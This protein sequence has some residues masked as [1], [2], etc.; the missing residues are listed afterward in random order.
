MAFAILRV[1]KLKTFGNIG[2]SLSHNY[3][4]R[5]TL[6]ADIERADLNEHDLKTN[7]QTMSA[8]QN[9]IPEKRRKDAVLCIEHLITASPHW[10]GWGTEKESEFFEKSKKWLEEKYGKDNLISTTIHR[11]ETTPHLVAYVVPLDESTGRLNA[12]K[13]LGGTRHTLT[14]MQTH[15]A[16]HVK[17]VGLE[18]GLQGSKAEH[19]TI[20]SYYAEIQKPVSALKSKILKIEKLGY[21]Q[22]PKYHFLDARVLHGERVMNAVYEN[23]EQQIDAFNND[24]KVSFSEMHLNFE[25][26]L[27][28]EKMRAD[29]FENAHEKAVLETIKL[30]EKYETISEYKRLFPCEFERLEQLLCDDVKNFHKNIEQ[31]KKRKKYQSEMLIKRQHEEAQQRENDFK[32]NISINRQKRLDSQYEHFLEKIARCTSEPEKIA[33]KRIYNERSVVL[34]SDPVNVMNEVL[35]TDKRNYYFGLCSL[36][37][38]VKNG[39][40]LDFTLK[41]CIKFFELTAPSYDEGIDFLKSPATRKVCA[42]SL[43]QLDN[44]LLKYGSEYSDQTE[45]LRKHLL[46]CE[47]KAE[48]D[49]FNYVFN[50]LN[51]EE[52]RKKYIAENTIDY[53]F[54]IRQPVQQQE[55]KKDKGFDFKP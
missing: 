46:A 48:Q 44:L 16:N 25:K 35:K 38:R 5:K 11:D 24:V 23:V 18:R 53:D 15:F 10:T 33:L 49:S 31:E 34:T 6:N 30:R 8:I 17:S 4:N 19:T 1:E 52:Q 37:F 55:R 21:D 3:R 28:A 50:D 27:A 14:K 29:K 20:K 7:Q 26:K 51:L 54:S 41:E 40:D 47:E 9:R 22:Q 12:K 42:A 13:W 45:V 39:H 43:N 2:G 32:K 36:L